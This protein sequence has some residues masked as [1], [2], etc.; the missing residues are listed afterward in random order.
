MPFD[1]KYQNPSLFAFLMLVRAIVIFTPLEIPNF[2][3]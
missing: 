3:K 1:N 2:L